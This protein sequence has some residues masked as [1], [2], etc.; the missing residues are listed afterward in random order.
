M[1]FWPISVLITF[2]QHDDLYPQQITTLEVAVNSVPS[3]V[4][5]VATQPPSVKIVNQVIIKDST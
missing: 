2:L 1:L 5:D 3:T 4:M